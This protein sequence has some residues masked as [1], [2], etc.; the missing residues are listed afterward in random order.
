MSILSK[1]L[2]GSVAK[3]YRKSY[4]LGIFL[5]DSDGRVAMPEVKDSIGNLP[6]LCHLRSHN[7]N[8]AVRWG[9]PQVFFAAPGV[10]SWMVPLVDRTELK[11]GLCGGYILLEDDPQSINASVN[12]LVGEGAKRHDALAFVKGLETFEQERVRE[13]AERLSALFYQYSGWNPLALKRNQD[14]MQ[15]QRQRRNRQQRE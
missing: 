9:E 3:E 10:M 14:Q 15:Q 11:G 7:L 4:G 8:E 12:Y 5:S 1:R 6:S 2:F 13:A